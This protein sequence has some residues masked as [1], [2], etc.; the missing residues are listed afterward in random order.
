MRLHK[1]IATATVVITGAVTVIGSGMIAGAE[2]TDTSTP[3]D[4]SMPTDTTVAADPVVAASSQFSLPL[5]G[6]SLV[7]DINTDPGGNLVDV[8]L[9]PA[10]GYTA[11]KLKP[12][13][14]Q[15][16]NEDGTVQVRVKTKHGQQR[17]DA[18][19]R[20]PRRRVRTRRVER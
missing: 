15:F 9:N 20:E 2:S 14:V 18:R 5:L 10:D 13:K 11:T 19:S 8:A 4:T 16:V 3:T 12:N 1:I 7:V 17:I 6:T